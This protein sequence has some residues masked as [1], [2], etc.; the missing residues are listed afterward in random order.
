MADYKLPIVQINWQERLGGGEVYT[1]FFSRALAEAGYSIRILVSPRAE[2]WTGLGFTKDQLVD[3]RGSQQILDALPDLQC[4]VLSHNA[5][6]PEL[7]SRIAERHLL[8]GIVHMPFHE[9]SVDGLSR[10]QRI[11]PVSAY[12]RDTLRAKGLQQ[13]WDE[14]LLGIADLSKR[15]DLDVSV[16]RRSVYEWDKRKFRERLGG[17]LEPLLPNSEERFARYPSLT[18]GV[19]SRLTPIKQFPML[20][21]YLAP[22]LTRFP[23]VRLE[24]FGSGGYATVRDIKRSLAPVANRVRFWGSQNNPAAVYPLLDYVLS[25]LPEKEALGLNL[26]EAQVA[27]TPVLAVDAP[28]FTETVTQGI[29]GFLYRD[30]RLDG[31]A[32]LSELIERL[33]NGYPRPDPRS[34]VDHLAKFGYLGFKERVSRA[35]NGLESKASRLNNRIT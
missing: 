29:S 12:V 24:I 2:Y 3:V 9:R 11:F 18:L 16:V 34:A 7:A 19:F 28:P 31:G 35:L 6:P 4:I 17:W 15:N 14:P 33:A 5:L 1:R 25:G 22:V 30:P 27:G 32:G 26:I 8:T 13:V 10:Y 21:S 23:N 20:F